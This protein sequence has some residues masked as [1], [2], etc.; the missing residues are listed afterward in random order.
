MIYT[1]PPWW[2]WVNPFAWLLWGLDILAWA[3]SIVGP[4]NTWKNW[5]TWNAPKSIMLDGKKGGKVLRHVNSIVDQPTEAAQGCKTVFHAVE[6]SAKRNADQL[7]ALVRTYIKTDVEFIDGKKVEKQVFGETKEYTFAQIW[8]S[9]LSFGRGLKELGVESFKSG[10]NLEENLKSKNPKPCSIL[11]YEDTCLEWVITMQGAFSQSVVVATSYAT[12]G[13]SSVVEAVNEGKISTIVCNW[14]SVDKVIEEC[15]KNCPTLK[16][17]IYTCHKLPQDK[18]FQE[19]KNSK[20]KVYSHAAVV[21]LGSTSKKELTP[22]TQD[23]TALVMYTSGSTGKPKGVVLSH[24]NLACGVSCMST[25]VREQLSLNPGDRILAY[26]PLAHIFELMVELTIQTLG[27]TLCFACPRSISSRGAKRL[28]PNGEYKTDAGYPFPPGAI[29]EYRPHVMVAVPKI[30]DILKT[31][32]EDTIAKASPVVKFL[33]QT[34]YSGKVWAMKQGRSSPLFDL[35]VFRK[36]KNLVGGCFKCGVSGG[37]PLHPKTQ[38][39]IQAV[40][41][42]DMGQGCGM[43]ENCAAGC[44]Q[45][46]GAPAY[47]SIGFVM[48]NSQCKLLATEIEDK[49]R[50]RYLPTD[51]MHYGEKCHG[52][53]EILWGGDAIMDGYLLMADKT[54]ET[55]HEDADGVWLRSGDVGVWT[56]DLEMKIVD[57]VK[58]IVKL[59]GGEYCA[60][61][62][63][64]GVYGT[65]PFVDKLAG[66]LMCQADGDMDRP[67]ALIHCSKKGLFDLAEAAGV[68][69]TDL[70]A[71]C[72][73]AAVKKAALAALN[74]IA[75]TEKL[76]A[77]EGLKAVHLISGKGDPNKPEKNSPWTPENEFEKI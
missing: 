74:T 45:N 37:G 35:L 52:R 2:V 63:I 41:C 56:A 72:A 36:T 25:A 32:V 46:M 50:K 12:L 76:G 33:F 54:K 58:N 24:L 26:L 60:V 57:R 49:E 8:Q 22:P 14:N 65:A 71:L 4:I 75:K 68:T 16:N 70:D 31:G 10:D 64:E 19:P 73:N 55:M 34:A 30:W 20:I 9:A 13:I 42:I 66:G 11:I 69:E 40:F 39:F 47:G 5:R 38:E 29:Q 18:D 48:S 3:F 43:T 27:I 17:I 77:N 62:H 6:D 28:M 67:C 15:S 21:S 61:E 1:C 59:K 51:T 23:C 44:V 7:A 53:G